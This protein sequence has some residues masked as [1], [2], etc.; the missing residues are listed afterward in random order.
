VPA[1]ITPQRPHNWIHK[2]YPAFDGLRAVAILMVFFAH[3]VPIAIYGYSLPGFW[4]GV[5]LFFVL[6]GFL[7][8][9]ILYDSQGNEHYFRN[10]YIRRS[11]RILPVFY[12]FFLLVFLLTPILHLQYS[13]YIWSNPLYI[14]NL[15][16]KGTMLQKHGNSTIILVPHLSGNQI[17]MG[18]LWSLCVEE[19]FY[20]VWP[21]IV[22]LVPSR[23]KLMNICV[24][25]ICLTV[26]LRTFLYFHD[27]ALAHQT[28]YLYNATYT[29]CD[30]LLVGAWIA[31]WLRGAT[32]SRE[33]LRRIAHIVF[34][35][36]L[37][38]IAILL[39]VFNR[40]WYFEFSDAVFQT[41]GYTLIAFACGAVIL[42]SL[43][44][45]SKVYKVLLHPALRRLGIISYGFYFFHDL[46]EAQFSILAAKLQP[47]HLNLLVFPLAFAYT[48][49]VA[50]LSF[51]Y[52]ESPFLR[53]KAI[54][55]PGHR[56]VPPPLP[57]TIPSAL[58]A[59]VSA[60]RGLPIEA[61]PA[62]DRLQSPTPSAQG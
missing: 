51:H 8:T 25:I 26:G 20:L 4:A 43:D 11:L 35:G 31:L 34:W 33:L 37:G 42:R 56:S 29:R 44:E 39:A 5:D 49:G 62:I 10:F 27:P 45:K 16:Y 53:L 22:W 19:Q 54:L 36:S 15:M 50:L 61:N 58:A 59:L 55:A 17:S 12:G 6:S 47:Y 30:T 52:L 13:K 40:R 23:T 7:I 9:G 18:V 46:P 28:K 48:Y 24:A 3:Y 1:E 57:T 2:Y 41:V 21:L 14:A 60:L 38:M 32:P